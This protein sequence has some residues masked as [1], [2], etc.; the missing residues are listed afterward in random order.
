MTTFAN[1]KRVRDRFGKIAKQLA[2]LRRRLEVKLGLV[3]QPVLVLHH[4]RGADAEHHVVRR[5]IASSQKMHIVRR[6]QTER[7]LFCQLR[8]HA[9]AFALHLHP[10]VVQLDEKVLRAQDVSILRRSL[11]CL[12]D[13]V[14]L[15]CRINF[16]RQATAQSD[17]SL[18]MR[19]QEFLV[20]PGRIMK[21]VEMRCCEQLYQI[22]IASLILRQQREMI[23]GLAPRP[24][25]IFVRSGR[26]I[27]L[28]TNNRFDS[29]LRRFL[30]KF[31]R[32]KKIP[33]IGDRHGRHLEFGRFLHQLPHPH[34]AIKQRILGMQMQMNEGVAGHV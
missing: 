21:T 24:G 25:P 1:L 9:I 11:S 8:Q 19:R 5:M 26:D 17:Q 15:D 4:L 18:G 10:V 3:A 14:R 7:E 34:R 12:G 29:R 22:A 16:A 33:V 27:C 31:D 2:H 32:A 23:S 6:D 20:D 30:I 28:A 13:V